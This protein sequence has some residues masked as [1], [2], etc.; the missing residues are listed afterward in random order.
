M[1]EK[2]SLDECEKL[3]PYQW[4]KLYGVTANRHEYI[5]TCQVYQLEAVLGN[6]QHSWWDNYVLELIDEQEEPMS[7]EEA[8][9][10]GSEPL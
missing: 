7:L 8:L 5:N 10:R 3:H 9:K 2:I 4:V 1:S 6:M